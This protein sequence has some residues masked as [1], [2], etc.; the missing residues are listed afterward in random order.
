VAQVLV[1]DE[2]IVFFAVVDWIL[3]TIQVIK[4]TS[5]W[6]E[7]QADGQA[8]HQ[9]MK[10]LVDVDWTKFSLV[11]IKLFFGHLDCLFLLENQSFDLLQWFDP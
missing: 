11:V 8:K 5:L 10:F 9:G 4:V 6:L 7:K 2:K 3:V 1:Q